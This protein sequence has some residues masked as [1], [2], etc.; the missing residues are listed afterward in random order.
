MPTS[1]IIQEIVSRVRHGFSPEKI[2]L[3][4]SLARGTARPDSDVDLLVVLSKVEDKRQS[5]IS[6]R[7][8]LSDLPVGKD[9]IVATED[10][11][12]QRGHLV[13]SVIREA[14]REGKTLYER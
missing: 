6:I 14:L 5:A 13:G 12:L 3:F 11:I 4:G 9:I 8:A 1:D 10:E 2:V 7:R